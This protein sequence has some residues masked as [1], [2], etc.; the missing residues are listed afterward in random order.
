MAWAEFIAALTA[1]F[2]SHSVPVRP[3]IR[4]RLVSGLGHRG[5][6]L[7]YS[8]LSLGALAWVIGAAGRAPFL[9]LW[10]WAPWQN[11]LVLIAMA[12]VCLLL[13]LS[14]GKPNPFSFGGFHN[15]RFDPKRPGLVRATRHPLLLALGLWAF[16][17]MVPNGDLA[18]VLLFGIFGA[19]ALAGQKIIDRRKQRQMGA[20]WAIL[21]DQTQSTD[22]SAA[23]TRFRGFALRIG[24]AA[25]LYSFLLWLHPWLFGVSP[26]A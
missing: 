3:K 26:L 18:H 4:A 23:V 7:G 22:I 6:T 20:D 11:A 10:A 14:I 21:W 9:V 15:E 2:L 13:A 8:I 12:L 16:A 17:H 1:F 5:F 24:I 25:L 19:F